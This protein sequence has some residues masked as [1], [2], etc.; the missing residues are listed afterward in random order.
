MSHPDRRSGANAHVLVSG[1]NPEWSVVVE[2]LG[3]KSYRTNLYVEQQG[4]TIA[5]CEDEDEAEQ[6]CTFIGRMFVLALGKLLKAQTEATLKKCPPTRKRK[7][8][9]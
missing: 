1:E 5:R 4:F 8:S 3:R 6:H 9:R 7:S 2:K